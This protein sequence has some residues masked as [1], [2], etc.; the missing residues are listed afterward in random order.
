MGKILEAT[1]E[2]GVVTADGVAVPAAEILSE[3]VAPSEGV[4][5]L[6]GDKAKYLTSS[7]SDLKSTIEQLI[8]A[9][10]DVSSALAS[11]DNRV[12]LVSATGGVPGA[13]V[14]GTAISSLNSAISDLEAFKEEL[15]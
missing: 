4:L 5:L 7:A 14:A 8:D 1:C 12:Y 11:I 2:D 15:K 9:L 3:G 10:E 6:E 13:A